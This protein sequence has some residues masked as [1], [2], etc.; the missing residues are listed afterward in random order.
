MKRIALFPLAALVLVGCQ[1]AQEPVGIETPEEPVFHVQTGGQDA[2]SGFGSA[3]VD[4]IFSPGEWDNAGSVDFLANVPPNDGGG[5]TPATLFVMNNA[6]NLYLALKIA[7]SSIG[8]ATNPSFEFDNN[9][10]GV[11][12]EGD[13]LFGMSEGIFSPPTFIDAFRTSQPPCPAGLCGLRDVDFGGTNDGTTDASNDGSFTYVEISHPLNSP[14][15]AHD[16]SLG[17]GDIV[18]FTLGLRLFSLDPACN[19]GFNCLA[20][21]DFPTFPSLPGFFGDIE[22]ASPATPTLIFD[23]LTAKTKCGMDAEDQIRIGGTVEG[24]DPSTDLTVEID[25]DPPIFG[26]VTVTIPAGTKGAVAMPGGKLKAAFPNTGTGEF[27]ITVDAIGLNDCSTGDDGAD[28]ILRLN[29]VEE[30]ITLQRAGDSKF[31]GQQQPSALVTFTAL[32]IGAFHSCGITVFERA[33]CWGSNGE[34]RLGSISPTDSAARNRPVPVRGDRAYRSVS[35]GDSHTCAI[36]AAGQA[37]CWGKNDWA[38]LGSGSAN[39]GANVDPILVGG[40]TFAAIDIG[41]RN[42]CGITESGALFC[43]GLGTSGRLGTGDTSAT[44]VPIPAVTATAFA[45]LALGEHHGCGIANDSL[46]YC[47]GDNSMGQLGATSGEACVDIFGRTTGCATTPT[48]VSPSLRFLSVSAGR[49][50]TCG[51][52]ADGTAYCWGDGS[53]GR[54]GTGGT[55]STSVPTPVA[56]GLMFTSV[57]AGIAHTCGVTT[58]DSVYCWG[59]NIVGQIGDGTFTDRTTPVQVTLAGSAKGVTSGASHTCALTTDNVAYCW[60]FNLSGQLGNG[61][62]VTSATPVMVLGQQ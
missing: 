44:L 39:N 36:D 42:T 49:S 9:H 31:R 54:L 5:T 43:W 48:L 20:D 30:S 17:A 32:E 7:R 28:L 23:I 29:G 10:N 11:R 46:L 26:P 45:A 40:H 2:L 33:Y 16:F 19:F 38:Q 35:A 57:S 21:T 22:I 12:N 62:N 4:G 3:T 56:G 50:H 47:W 14:D 24:F 34:G 60:G 58:D 51:I 53:D 15:D 13:D 27:Q 52:T 18:G 8:G 6:T 25:G 59:S 37:Y 41:W 61:M 1:D 55:D